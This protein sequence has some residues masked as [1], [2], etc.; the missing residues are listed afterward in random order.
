MSDLYESQGLSRI[1]EDVLTCGILSLFNPVDLLPI[2]WTC[3]WLSQLL[4]NHPIRDHITRNKIHY[5]PSGGPSLMHWALEVAALGVPDIRHVRLRSD[6]GVETVAWYAD[7]FGSDGLDHRAVSAG[8]IKAL[9]WLG[10]THLR[11]RFSFHLFH[12]VLRLQDAP[13]R[14]EFLHYLVSQGVEITND[15]IERAIAL[16]RIEEVQYLSSHCTIPGWYANHSEDHSVS[17]RMLKWF[18]DHKYIIQTLPNL[19]HLSGTDRSTWEWLEYIG[20]SHAQLMVAAVDATHID[21]MQWV[22][23]DLGHPIHRRLFDTLLSKDRDEETMRRIVEWLEEKGL[24]VDDE[25]RQRMSERS[26]GKREN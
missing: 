25:D 1:P 2:A 4:Q 7:R 5:L 15:V 23:H 8:N 19:S 22:H 11:G 6:D 3:H 24:E 9:R 13:T 14:M 18:V 16:D 12:D 21:M 10:D 17:P 26:L 20:Y